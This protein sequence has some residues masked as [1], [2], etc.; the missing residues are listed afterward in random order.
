MPRRSH[1][2]H[3]SPGYMW[4]AAERL[5][6]R[7]SATVGATKGLIANVEDG[8]AAENRLVTRLGIEPRT[9]GLKVPEDDSAKESD[10]V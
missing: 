4:A 5:V 2:S 3:V 9:P 10:Q 1:H 7:E 6:G 8:V